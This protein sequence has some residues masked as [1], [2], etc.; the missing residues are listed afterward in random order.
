MFQ[1][2]FLS[3]IRSSK[4]HICQAFVR[5]LLLPAGSQKNW[6]SLEL[7]LNVIVCLTVL[8]EETVLILFFTNIC[9][10]FL[11]PINLIP[12]SELILQGPCSTYWPI[13]L[14]SL[15]GLL[16][17]VSLCFALPLFV[18]SCCYV[19]FTWRYLECMASWKKND[20]VFVI[21]NDV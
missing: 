21:I 10:Q 5:P 20:S 9:L 11:P 16:V 6:S 3:I 18:L 15:V 8:A 4:L 7:I 19:Y 14:S 12:K 13:D 1:T 17:R 2:D